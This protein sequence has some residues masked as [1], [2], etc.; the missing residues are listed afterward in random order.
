MI[1]LA[2]SSTDAAI[3]WL[4]N[5]PWQVIVAGLIIMY[6]WPYFRD[7]W[8]PSVM[9]LRNKQL[10]AALATE[11]ELL[12]VMLKMSEGLTQ[13]KPLLEQVVA[14]QH[15]ILEALRYEEL[16]RLLSSAPRE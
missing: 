16:K 3:S 2:Q 9:A 13:C 15:D 5:H 6:V 10:D 7:N 11:K 1:A 4:A 14:Q 12:S 8:L